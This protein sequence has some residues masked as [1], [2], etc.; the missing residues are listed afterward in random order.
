MIRHSYRILWPAAALTAC[1]ALGCKSDDD[2]RDPKTDTVNSEAGASASG[3]DAAVA[4]GAA[5]GGSGASGRLDAGASDGGRGNRGNDGRGNQRPMQECPATR[6]MNGS[7]CVSGR[8]DCTI[9][10]ATCDCPD[11]TNKWVCW[12]PSDCPAV[13]PA[14]MAAC[15]VVGMQCDIVPPAAGGSE[16][17]ECECTAQGWDCGRQA[18]PAAEPAAGGVCEGGDG[19][20]TFGGRVCDCRGKMWVCWNASDCPAAPPTA[21]SACPVERMLCPYPNDECECTDEGWECESQEEEEEE[22]GEEDEDEQS[23]EQPRDGSV[24][25]GDAGTTSDGA[26][27]PADAATLDSSR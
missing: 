27:S 25:V 18:C 7:A 15:S 8:G 2:D 17:L 22:E 16:E 9:G 10:T 12:E 26:A 3:D 14:E 1:L 20:C 23:G 13:A 21:M 11:D 5:D 4:S 19:V 6:P 24:S